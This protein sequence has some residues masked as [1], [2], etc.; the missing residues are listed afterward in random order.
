MVYS[1]YKF[2]KKK[3]RIRNMFDALFLHGS[4]V[5]KIRKKKLSIFQIGKRIIILM[6][7][8]K[9]DKNRLG[10]G[11]YKQ[12]GKAKEG[13]NVISNNVFGALFLFGC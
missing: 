5:L 13:F 7:R 2:I 4:A 1:I 6:N 12:W 3:R 11:V 9:K 8:W 10:Q